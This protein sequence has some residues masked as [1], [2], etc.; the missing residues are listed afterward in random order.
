M[1]Y[2]IIGLLV[3]F[4]IVGLAVATYSSSQLVETF[5]KYNAVP[6][7]KKITGGEF[8]LQLTN[9]F[10]GA[11]INVGRTKG[12]LN[13]G[14]S[15]KSKM[16]VLSESTCDTASVAALTIVA[17]EFGHASQDLSKSKRFKVNKILTKTT[18]FL[19]YFM[20]PLAM[21]GLF[22]CLIM[23]ESLEIGLSLVGTSAGILILCV[24]VKLALIPLEKDASK[25]GIDLLIKTEALFGEELE[26]AKDLLN[27]ALL[28]YIGD[29]LRSIL[30]WTFLTRKTKYF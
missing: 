13:D 11:K 28:T 14:Y 18:R 25:R 21:V 22:L 15:S 29:F 26:M 23:P 24:A 2:V 10:F 3:V 27:A 30:W 5:E 17:H 12:F 9:N 20:F 16:V 6:C 19:G 4:L 1:L 7:Y 8:A